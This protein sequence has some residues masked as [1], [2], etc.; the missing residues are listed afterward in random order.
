M[1]DARTLA[2][3]LAGL[4]LLIGASASAQTLTRGPFVQNPD[5]LTTTMTILWWTNTV[6]DSTVEYGT[7]L[8]LGQSKNVAQAAT[9]E[10]GAAGTCHTVQLTGLTPGTKYFYQLKTNGV[11]VVAASSSIYFHTFRAPADPADLHFTVVGDWGAGTGAT[12]N[13]ANN[14]NAADP[15]LIVT[16]GDN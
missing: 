14:Q 5:A 1:R 16:T 4:I 2:R 6:G 11:T 13:V 15:P 9:C 12:T 7:T 10:I 8:A 3:G